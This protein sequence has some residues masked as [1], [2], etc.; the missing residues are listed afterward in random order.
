[1]TGFDRMQADT[2]Q[3]Y[4]RFGHR[5][6]PLVTLGCQKFVVYT[7]NLGSWVHEISDAALDRART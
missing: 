5:R 3:I 1:M 6:Q 7:Y 4:V 2:Y